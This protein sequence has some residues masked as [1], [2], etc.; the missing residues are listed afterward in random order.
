M[1]HICVSGS[2]AY[3][4]IYRLDVPFEQKDAEHISLVSDNFV[5]HHGGTG[6][7]IAYNLALLWE[8]SILLSS[9]GTDYSFSHFI[10][11]KINLKYIHK[12]R[13]LHSTHVNIVIDNEWKRMS[14]YY[15]GAMSLATESKIEYIEENIWVGI[16]SAG[17]IGAMLKHAEWMQKKWIPLIVDPAQQ[18][19]YMSQEEL[20][21]FL[22]FWDILICNADEFES[23][24]RISKCSESELKDMFRCIIVTHGASG[25]EIFTRSESVK[26]PAISVWDVDDTTGAGDSYRAALLYGLIEWWDIE[27]SCKLW[28]LLASYCL[29]TPGSQQHHV[30]YG[31]IM[32]DMKQHFDEE[33]DLYNRRKY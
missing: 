28:S 13:E 2:S 12:D 10:E 31:T 33:I 6:A 11:E 25:S 30:S 15:P 8:N 9:V 23:I 24:M 5:R 22:E 32:E 17:D 14:C 3:D 29:L 4:N 1:K 20:T 27:K 26:I 21:Q 18:T 16:V 19:Q 7:N